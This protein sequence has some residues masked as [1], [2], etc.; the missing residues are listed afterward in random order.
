M[1]VGQWTDNGI[2]TL[3]AKKVRLV[4]GTNRVAPANAGGHF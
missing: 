2:S 1:K 4:Y 3:D